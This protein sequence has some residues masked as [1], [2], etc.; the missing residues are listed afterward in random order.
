MGENRTYKNFKSDLAALEG[1]NAFWASL[2]PPQAFGNRTQQSRTSIAMCSRYCLTTPTEALKERLHPWLKAG[3]ESAWL[4]HYAPRDLIRPGEPVLALRQEHG[5]DN[6]SHM[7]WGLLPGWVKDPAKGPRPFNARSETL[8]Q[9][10]SFRGPWRH[11]R[12]LLPCDGFLEKGRRIQRHDR[13]TFWLA[14]LWD[15]WIG[16]DGSEVETCCVITTEPNALI[17]PLHDRMPVIMPS[18]LEEAWLQPGD[19]QHRRALEPMLQP[20]D[21]QDWC[22]SPMAGQS[23]KTTN[24]QLRLL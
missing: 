19:G 21:P 4:R 22:C 8:E 20:W 7:L 9:K 11:Q 6:L 23:K 12:C 2:N 13:Q 14:G 24:E 5:Q 10:A 1:Q 17:A 15:R 3:P 16:P 18:G